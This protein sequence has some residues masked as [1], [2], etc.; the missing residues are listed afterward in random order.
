MNEILIKRWNQVVKDGHVIF[1][2]GDF[3]FCGKE[4]MREIC[5]QLNGYKYLII[6]NHDL[7]NTAFYR[8]IGFDEVSK[9]PII[10]QNNWILSHQP[11]PLAPDSSKNEST[12]ESKSA[13]WPFQKIC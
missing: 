11:M 8:N 4:P 2:L 1:V 3:A 5:N 6:G 10:F 9:Y 7:K 12:I 13:T